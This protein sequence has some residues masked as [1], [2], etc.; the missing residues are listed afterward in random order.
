MYE[1]IL[2][3]DISKAY[4]DKVN[5]YL[6][7]GMT[8]YCSTMSG[9]QGEICKIDVTDWQ[10]IYRINLRK[11]YEPRKYDKVILTVE[12]FKHDGWGVLQDFATLWN[13][14]GEMIEEKTWYA[15]DA[16]NKAF[17][18]TPIESMYY[19]S[20]QESRRLEREKSR[21]EITDTARLTLIYKYLKKQ[22][23]YANVTKKSI[24]RVVARDDRAKY[25][26]T[27]TDESRKQPFWIRYH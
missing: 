8:L 27:F 25:L 5:E 14:K 20:I 17:V 26:V 3:K 11:E 6:A 12:K 4:T 15:I 1:I 9:S 18:N 24:K 7:K 19:R 23:G 2:P 16:D 22:K 13:G 10:Y 21:R